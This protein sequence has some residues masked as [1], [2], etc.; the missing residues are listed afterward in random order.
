MTDSTHSQGLTFNPAF[1]EAINQL[2]TLSDILFTDGSQGMG[3]ELQGVATPGIV[4][5]QLT[6]DGQNLHYFNQ[7]AEWKSFRWP[8]T[9]NKP[10]AMLSW[11]SMAA[12]P[13]IGERQWPVGHAA[14]AGE[15][16]A[17]AD[18]RWAVSPDGQYA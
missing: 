11:S 18:R 2:S 10:G 15:N 17:P 8:G 16:E 5:T 9:I 4:E 1:L 3:F 6:L 14:Y 13:A 12:R 7:L